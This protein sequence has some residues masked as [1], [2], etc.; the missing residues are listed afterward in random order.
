MERGLRS[1]NENMEGAYVTRHRFSLEWIC[2][3]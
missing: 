3:I 2:A 1:T